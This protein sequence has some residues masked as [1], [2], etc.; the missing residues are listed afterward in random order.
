MYHIFCVLIHSYFIYTFSIMI[1]IL[2]IYAILAD[3][4]LSL[5]YVFPALLG[6]CL[7]GSRSLQRVQRMPSLPPLLSTLRYA[8]SCTNGSL[9][10]RWCPHYTSSFTSTFFSTTACGGS[11]NVRLTSII[12]TTSQ[13]SL[14]DT[15]LPMLSGPISWSVA[16]DFTNPAVA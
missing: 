13:C 7:D 1:V 9:T 14:S 12:D 16:M 4:W 3:E 5:A 8:V 2:Y 11:P 15:V 6:D 10:S